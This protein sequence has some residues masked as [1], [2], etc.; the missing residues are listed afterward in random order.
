[1]YRFRVTVSDESYIRRLKFQLRDAD[2]NTGSFDNGQ[3]ETPVDG[4]S[5]EGWVSAAV[6]L[7][8]GEVRDGVVE[9]RSKIEALVD[10][11]DALHS[12]FGM[13]AGG[14]TV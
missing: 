6:A 12:K 14:T 1:M 2:G 5:V 3:L 13:A 8:I 9:T 10:S 4:S 7:G 11:N